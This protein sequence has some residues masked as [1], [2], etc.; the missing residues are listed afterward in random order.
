[1][2]RADFRTPRLYVDAALSHGASVP[3]APEQSN[4]LGNVLRLKSGD[5]VLAF[6]G[7]DGEW[8]AAIAG[9][10]RPEQLDD[11]RRRPGRRKRRRA[12]V[13]PSRR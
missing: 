4:Y 3:L 2:P 12:C 11:R 6:N 10:K 1:M 7:R 8:R 5:K 9:R 13:T